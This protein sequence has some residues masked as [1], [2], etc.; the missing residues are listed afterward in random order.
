M[1][2]AAGCLAGYER[3]VAIAMTNRIRTT[4]VALALT[5][6]SS[7]VAL[8]GPLG[9]VGT[10]TLTR[11]EGF[12][13]GA[14][15]EF[16]VYNINSSVVDNSA[17]SATAPTKNVVPAVPNSFQTFCLEM[18]ENAA[19][20]AT[21]YFVVG[22]SAA[23]GGG[24]SSKDN[25][26]AVNGRDQ[27][28]KG[29]AW[30]YSQFAQGLLNVPKVGATKPRG[31]YFAEGANSPP[32]Y[33]EAEMLQKA[34]WWLEQEASPTQ[35]ILDT[36]P[37]YL[38]AIDFFKNEVGGA[39]A[40]ADVGFLGVYVLNNFKTQSALNTYLATGNIYA[41]P[42]LE[43]AQDFLWYDETPVPDGGVTVMLL[44]GALVGLGALRRRI[45]H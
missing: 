38:K 14:G 31:D 10:F 5:M 17:Y 32:R 1:L 12:R 20:N 30:L 42:T 34:I 35:D 43:R 8:A 2:D 23:A 6:G 36:N 19:L 9:S 7:G 39:K 11:I 3:K 44:G 41:T 16:T 37:Y 25:N 27:I 40:N 15:G 28:S 29:T 13:A 4:V 26:G 22:S 33:A 18:T 21:N 45:K 24:G